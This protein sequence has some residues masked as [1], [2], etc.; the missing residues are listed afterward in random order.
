MLK[1][2]SPAAIKLEL[3][4]ELFP[5]ALETAPDGSVRVNAAAIQQ[6]L[7]PA[8]PG[9]IRVEE[10][11]Y[12]LRWVGKREAYHSAFVPPQKILQPLP[13]DSQ[14]WDN[15]GNL[16]IKGDN[17]D[18]LRLLRHS[19]FGKVKLIYIDP[20]YNTQ[21]DAFIYR[22]DFSARQSEVLSAL[23]YSADNIDYI[24][25]IYGARTHSGWLSFMYPRLLLAKDLLRDDGVIFISI[26]DNEQAQLKL[27]CDEVFGQENF[28]AQLVWEGA[29]KNDARQVGTVHEYVLIYASNRDALP[30]DWGIKKEGADPVF[31]EVAR[32]K[33]V[34]GED[35]NAASEGL[36]NW[37]RA[38]KSTPSYMLRRFRYIDSHG[39]YKEDDPT[40]PGGRKFSLI[41]PKTG[42]VI[43]LRRNRGW[44]FDQAEFDRLVADDRISFITDTS[45]MVRRYLHETDSLTPPS[46]YYQAA[47][48]ASER[49]GKLL[50]EN[51]F[52]FPKDETVLCKFI[53]MATDSA[54]DNCIV[55]DFFAGSGTTAH[56]VWKQN[57]SDGGK[58]K[59]VLVQIPEPIEPKKQKEAYAFVT[60]T[61]AKPEA[62][63]FEITAERLRRAG[64]KLKADKPDLDTGFRVFE[65]ADDPDALILQKPLSEATQDDL[66]TLQASIATPQPAQLPRILYNL[67]LAEGL[68][69]STRIVPLR[70][71]AL[72]RAA[73]VLLIL[74]EVDTEAL[75][76][77]LAQ[78]KAEG[79][80]I[81]HLCVYAPWV[82]DNNFLLGAKT[83]LET[84]GLSEDKLRLRG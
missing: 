76:Q 5:Q 58:R 4:R 25:N 66:A 1:A 49:L 46:V 53:E 28:V 80:P 16:L 77:A 73:D 82:Q 55:V 45:V 7:D 54:D 27:L 84:L 36:G 21:S 71:Q 75:G 69:L 22:D 56:A 64:A 40:A 52:D 24:K 57:I 10:D 38:M 14:D 43:P 63:I 59:F 2:P 23:G 70:E 18:A 37:F 13:D 35:H 8:N 60:E 20:P 11:G 50:A 51:V 47:R 30:R 26:D 68:A 44:A 41:N 67:L 3:L 19:Y 31:A 6:A 39:A 42:K 15:T 81:Q 61:L 29:N 62:T 78:M 48:S 65:L 74:H 12:E 33:A 79:T 34:H 32:L 17:L 72:Y 9:G 83:L